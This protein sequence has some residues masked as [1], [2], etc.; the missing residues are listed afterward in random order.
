[1]K[2]TSIVSLRN[3]NNDNENMCMCENNRKALD[4]AWPIYNYVVICSSLAA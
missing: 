2:K 3:S 1:M 4:M